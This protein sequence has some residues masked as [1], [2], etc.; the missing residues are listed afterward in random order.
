M[1]ATDV[2]LW[3]R[4]FIFSSLAF[5]FAVAK[6]CM[7]IGFREWLVQTEGWKDWFKHKEQ[8][9]PTPDETEDNRLGYVRG[10]TEKRKKE[11]EAANN[12]D[13][14][15]EHM[16]ELEPGS[17]T[18]KR[19]GRIAGLGQEADIQTDLG[20][21]DEEEAQRIQ[22]KNWKSNQPMPTSLS[23]GAEPTQGGG[24]NPFDPNDNPNWEKAL[25]AAQKQRAGG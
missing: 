1:Q 5:L 11:A 2:P 3:P 4:R 7:D 25:A 14:E 15:A 24:W 9:P 6:Y 21:S 19:A 10:T 12:K 16:L 18:K 23:F 13:A 20:L 17:L 22:R 8:T